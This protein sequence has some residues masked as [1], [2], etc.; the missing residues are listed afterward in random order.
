VSGTNSNEMGFI[1]FYF[2]GIVV[3]P[4]GF[5]DERRHIADKG[6]CSGKKEIGGGEKKGLKS[7]PNVEKRW[8]QKEKM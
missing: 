3:F 6:C 4:L 8:N 2:Y 7:P 5:T 1:F